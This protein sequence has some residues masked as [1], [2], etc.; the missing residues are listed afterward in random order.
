[1]RN[2]TNVD[3]SIA[4]FNKQKQHNAKCKKQKQ[5]VSRNDT[6]VER[7]KKQSGKWDVITKK[8]HKTEEKTMFSSYTK[9]HKE[10]HTT[11]C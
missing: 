5:L 1:M 6:V 9:S 11:L 10:V 2:S 7:P 3:K 8:S 4:D